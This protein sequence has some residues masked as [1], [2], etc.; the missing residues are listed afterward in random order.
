M[1]VLLKTA[2]DNILQKTELTQPLTY[3]TP[4]VVHASA[5]A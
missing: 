3:K 1:S 4:A 2:Y 5:V